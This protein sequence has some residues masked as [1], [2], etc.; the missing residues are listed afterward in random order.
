MLFPGDFGIRGSLYVELRMY[1][2]LLRHRFITPA[3][4]FPRCSSSSSAVSTPSRRLRRL[5]L[6]CFNSGP[7]AHARSL[8]NKATQ[9]VG[10]IENSKHRHYR[11]NHRHIWTYSRIHEQP[12]TLAYSYST[13]PA[14]QFHSQ[15]DEL[16]TRERPLSRLIGSTASDRV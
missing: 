8:Q 5:Y 14:A 15:I 10:V 11:L 6:T 2:E 13:T 9:L 16:Y 1:A 3:E 4:F 12:Q 7:H